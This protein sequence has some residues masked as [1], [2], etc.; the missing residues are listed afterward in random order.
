MSQQ[1]WGNYDSSW[2]PETSPFAE[3]LQDYYYEPMERMTEVAST[4]NDILPGVQQSSEN[5]TAAA[6]ALMDLPG[7][8]QTA[9]ASGMSAISII[10]DASGI[11]AMQ[12]RIAGGISDKLVKMTK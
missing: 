10:I 11:D 12:P 3:N 5:M 6:T 8:I 2:M 9:I 1:I 4:Q 7:L